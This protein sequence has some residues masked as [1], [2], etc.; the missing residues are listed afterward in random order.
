MQ[1]RACLDS[2]PIY[3]YYR[4]NSPEKVNI[5]M[6]KIKKQKIIAYVP[7]VIL[8]EVFKH[9]CV[10]EGKDF[11]LSCLTSFQHNIKAQ[12]VPLSSELILKT[13][14]LKCQ[15]RTKLSYNDCVAI[16]VALQKKAK[17]HSTEKDFPKIKNLYIIKYEF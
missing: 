15:Y 1:E 14:E 10:S 9:I 3:L 12:H 6:N 7:N 13:G 2:G 5:L 17:L 8:I 11:A 16:A 4:K